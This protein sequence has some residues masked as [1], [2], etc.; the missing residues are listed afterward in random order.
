TFGMLYWL[1]PRL[2]QT[3]LWSTKAA[4]MHF[5]L[6]TIGILLYIVPIYVAGLTQGLM[7][8]AMDE[9]GQL[10]YP[11]FVETISA[12]APMWWLRVFGGALYV[13]GT[14]LMAVNYVMTWKGRPAT[15]KTPTYQAPKLKPIADYRDPEGDSEL[16][17]APV[18][19]LARKVDVWSKMGW[20]RRWER[21]P[22]RFTVL[23]TLAVVTASL[24]EMVPTFLI[25]S[26]VPTIAS[27]QPYTPLELAGRDIFVAE[28]CYNCHS[29]MIRPMVAETK[30]YGEYS[31]PGESVYDHPFQW[32]SRRIGPD[33]AREGGKQSSLWHY[34]HLE[35]PQAVNEQSVMP[36]Y[37]HLLDT[38]IDFNKVTDRVWAAHML[39][40]PYDDELTDAPELARRQA[41]VVAA[42]IVSQGGP[43]RRGDVMTLDSQAVAL[44]AYLQRIGIDLFEPAPAVEPIPDV[45]ES[46]AQAEVTSTTR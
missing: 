45:E 26:N 11:D 43:I 19:D 16:K 1:L 5:W 14:L 18:L 46:V 23:T 38:P 33:L 30:R 28:G 2:F 44:I 34:L 40:A 20:H 8:R 25:R 12:V 39:G 24:F 36:A 4:S 42:D 17:A 37:E 3:Q 21:L 22:L 31:K 27:V 15:Y 9:T 10:V 32:G 41:E 6:S 7:W 13:G 29:Q 35:N